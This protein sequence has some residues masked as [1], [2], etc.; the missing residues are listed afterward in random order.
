[1][2]TKEAGRGLRYVRVLWV[3]AAYYRELE[4]AEEAV[5]LDMMTVG[6]VINDEELHIAIAHEL[7]EDG[8]YRSVTSIPKAW[9][10]EIEDLTPPPVELWDA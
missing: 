7:C 6:V 10:K 4:V 9:I 1:M 8:T 3:D 2:W 5:P